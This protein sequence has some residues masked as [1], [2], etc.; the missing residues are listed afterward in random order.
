M[1]VFNVTKFFYKNL[2]ILSLSANLESPHNYVKRFLRKKKHIIFLI[3]INILIKFCHICF[4]YFK[5]VFFSVI[6]L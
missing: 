5:S 3:F 4:I 6:N 1:C 2:H